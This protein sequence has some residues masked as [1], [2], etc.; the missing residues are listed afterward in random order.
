VDAAGFAA[1]APESVAE[2]PSVAVLFLALA[3]L[4]GLVGEVVL[5]RLVEDL[6]LPPAAAWGDGGSP[7]P[8]W[9]LPRGLPARVGDTISGGSRHH[10]LCQR[11]PSGQK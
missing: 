5:D 1:D 6:G 2:P 10:A 4:A 11:R 3:S 8:A 9:G 7:G